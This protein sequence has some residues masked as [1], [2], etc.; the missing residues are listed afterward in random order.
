MELNDLNPELLEKARGC[1]SLEE[2]RELCAAEGIVL[3]DEELAAVAGGT[4]CPE[5]VCKPYGDGPRCRTACGLH[6]GSDPSPDPCSRVR[7]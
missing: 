3:S 4:D 2:L 1:T 7:G 6:F 5:N